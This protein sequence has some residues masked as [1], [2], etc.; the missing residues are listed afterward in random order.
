[1]RENRFHQLMLGGFQLLCNCVTLDKLCDFC[2]NHMRA[3]ELASFRVKDGFD[4][5]FRFA[6]SYRFAISDIREAADFYIIS[7]GFGLSFSMTNAGNL[8]MAICT[9]RNRICV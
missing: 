9:A 5:T 7:R 8:W 4:K 6:Q 1:M 2:A 3:Q